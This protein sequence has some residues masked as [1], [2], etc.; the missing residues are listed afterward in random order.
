[1]LN[2]LTASNSTILPAIAALYT[3]HCPVPLSLTGLHADRYIAKKN[4]DTN[5]LEHSVLTIP[6]NI[7]TLLLIDETRLQPGALSQPALL[8][9]KYLQT[10]I[11]DSTITIDYTYSQVTLNVDVIPIILSLGKS[12]L[13]HNVEVASTLLKQRF[14]GTP[15]QDPQHLHPRICCP[16]SAQ[17]INAPQ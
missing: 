16:S 11:E 9:V 5:A 2:I 12:F 13:P 7:P 15:N 14:T 10:L 6:T 1:M 8:N 3:P 17:C 4:L